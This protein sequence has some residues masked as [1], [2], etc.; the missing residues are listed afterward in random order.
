[1]EGINLRKPI[2]FSATSM[3]VFEAGERHINR[4]CPDCVLLAVFE[5]VLRFSENG[6]PYEIGAGE[7]FIQRAGG[8]QEGVV[9][10]DKPTYFYAHFEADWID[11]AESETLAR[12]GRF[13]PVSL[14][15]MMESLHKKY[16]SDKPWIS[17][18]TDF[19]RLIELLH[20]GKPT[21]PQT[22]A[23][24]MADYLREH[25]TDKLSMEDLE[26]QFH[27]SK[28][29]LILL[30]RREYGVTPFR[31]VAA[32]RIRCAEILLETTSHSLEE[33]AL[34]C[35]FSDYSHFFKSFR[36]TNGMTPKKWRT[37]ARI[38]NG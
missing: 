10:S 12:R 22:L 31:F 17:M 36:T 25:A 7:Y 18:S 19:Y 34:Q 14:R 6:M 16:R 29:Y 27:F 35:G 2:V 11:G 32:V 5:G 28:N 24:E 20:Q 23:G 33:I 13:D 15:P 9:P 8:W 38:C 26:R 21:Q 3:R 1:M 30:F 37:H 4:L